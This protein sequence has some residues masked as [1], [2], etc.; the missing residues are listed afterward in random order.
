MTKTARLIPDPVYPGMWRVR[1]PD[2]R[3]SDMANL[4]RAKDAIAC[5]GES[6]E[7]RN[8]G[9]QSPRNGPGCVDRRSSTSAH[10]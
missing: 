10:V 4:T 5:F 8:R 9:R 1:W 2:G 3:L 6:L 7:R